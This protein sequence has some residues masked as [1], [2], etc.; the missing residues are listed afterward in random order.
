MPFWEKTGRGADWI[1]RGQ[2]IVQL[3]A[4]F[5]AGRVLQWLAMEYGHLPPILATAVWLLATAGIMWLLLALFKQQPILQKN[6]QIQTI[7]PGDL[8]EALKATDDF[9]KFNN[10]QTLQDVEHRIELIAAQHAK[11]DERDKWMLRT[12]SAS[13]VTYMFDTT[14]LSIYRSQLE[15]VQELNR[16]GVL[17]I[18]SLKSFY[19]TAAKTYAQTYSNYSFDSWLGY[20]QG[21]VLITQTGTSIQITTRGKE[22]LKY[23]V[24]CGLS[25]KIK[26][27]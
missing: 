17:D 19:D 22:F 10:G 1:I 27:Y 20:L 24:Q 16:R 25:E 9:Y 11:P 14:W 13:A 6:A 18:N 15:A 8:E 3:I 7:N 2:A 23:L 4:S 12:I 5:G 26:L 21:H